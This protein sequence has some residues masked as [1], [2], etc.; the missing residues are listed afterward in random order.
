MAS[1]GVG[2]DA[3][4]SFLVSARKTIVGVVNL[5]RIKTY[6][7]CLSYIAIVGLTVNPETGET[8]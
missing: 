4:Y 8:I 5:R 1:R 6:Y 7:T 2:Q 3:C